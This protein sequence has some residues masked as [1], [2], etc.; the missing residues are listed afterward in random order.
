MRSWR[1]A[2][3]TGW[4]AALVVTGCGGDRPVAP[5]QI[6]YGQ[7]LCVVCGMI[8]SDDRFAAGLAVVDDGGDVEIQAFDD[9]GC[10]L[11]RDVVPGQVAGRWVRDFAGDAWREAETAVYLHSGALHSPMAYG[12]A[13]FGTDD[14]ARAAMTRFPGEV[15]PFDELRRRFDAGTLVAAARPPGG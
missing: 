4:L 9:V 8:I 10:L 15:L 6:L 11:A 1:A 13:A 12:V 2:L 7:D 5:P 3:S 14:D